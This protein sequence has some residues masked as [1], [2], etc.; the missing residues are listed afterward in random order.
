MLILCDTTRSL[1][2]DIAYPAL[3]AI[4]TAFCALNKGCVTIFKVLVIRYSI[5]LS[6]SVQAEPNSPLSLSKPSAVVLSSGFAA[7]R[8]AAN[9]LAYPPQ[10]EIPPRLMR[11]LSE[12]D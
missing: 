3:S 5:V 9:V 1:W 11:L 2:I 8:A 6:H 7:A 12:A 4:V 10:E